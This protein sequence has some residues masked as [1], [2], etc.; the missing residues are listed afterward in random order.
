M[1]RDD[2][3]NL[4]LDAITVRGGTARIAEIGKYIW[5]RHESDLRASGDFFYTWQYEMRWA[6]NQLARDGKLDKTS[7]KGTWK[8]LP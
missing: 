6:S 4:I 2:L 3:K 5:D 8:K 1:K 7:T